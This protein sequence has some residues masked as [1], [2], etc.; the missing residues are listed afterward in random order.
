M[1]MSNNIQTIATQPILYR[2]DLIQCLIS[3]G[4]DTTSELSDT[5]P[6]LIGLSHSLSDS[7]VDQHQILEELSDG[8]VID[9][10]C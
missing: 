1:A 10:G 2:V 8:I 6:L 5:T 4:S 9:L 3:I 7:L